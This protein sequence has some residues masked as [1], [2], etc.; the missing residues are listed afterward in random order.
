MTFIL[1]PA[2]NQLTASYVYLVLSVLF[3]CGAYNYP[4]YR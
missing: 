2:L 4:S 1:L 3:R